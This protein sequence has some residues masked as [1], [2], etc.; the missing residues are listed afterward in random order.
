L[1]LDDSTKGDTLSPSAGG[2]E[3][4]KPSKNI[5]FLPDW[6]TPRGYPA[7]QSGRNKDPGEASP[8][9]TPPHGAAAHIGPKRGFLEGH[10]EG[11]R[12]LQT[13]LLPDGGA[14]P[15]P[16]HPCPYDLHTNGL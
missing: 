9:Q 8:P 16:S 4:C 3:G 1:S 5:V 7:A 2:L 6:A 15:V 13:S 11:T 14:A 12:S 10:P